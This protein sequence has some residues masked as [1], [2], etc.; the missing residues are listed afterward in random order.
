MTQTYSR[1]GKTWTVS[2][3]WEQ[4]KK[5]PVTERLVGELTVN[6]YDQVLWYDEGRKPTFGD[7]MIHAYRMNRADLNYP[8]ILSSNGR[9]MDGCHRLAKAALFGMKTVKVVQFDTDPDPDK[10]ESS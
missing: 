5:L 3:L 6:L 4:A 7:F 1:N 8:I 10:D 2:R 9:V